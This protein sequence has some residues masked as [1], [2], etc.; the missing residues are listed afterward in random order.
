MFGLIDQQL[1]IV[2]N[3][4]PREQISYLILPGGL[5]SSPYVQKRARARYERGGDLRLQNAQDLRV[6]LA[7]EP[8]LAVCHG[9]VVARTQKLRSGTE[10]YTLRCS[11]VSYGLLCREL[12]NPEKHQGETIIKDDYSDTM[13]ALGQVNWI[14]RRGEAVSADEGV[15]QKYRHKLDFTKPGAPQHA[16]ILMSSLPSHQLPSSMRRGGVKKVCQIEFVVAPDHLKPKNRHW[17]NR[18]KK[19]YRA[20]YEVRAIIA[21]GL[22]FQIW[23]QDGLLS[24]SHDEIEVQWQP[25]DGKAPPPPRH[26]VAPDGLYRY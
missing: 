17:Y 19:Y 25:V 13:W 5:S 21:A 14:I 22:S 8:Q 2:Q 15:K 18:G 3:S 4:H 23:G 6:L 1:Q 10:V 12:Y 11:P 9:L 20:E 16:T 7:A 24:K 26:S